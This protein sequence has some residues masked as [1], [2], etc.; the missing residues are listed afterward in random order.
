M[1]PNCGGNSAANVS[2]PADA[3][4]DVVHADPDE[5]PPRYLK[6]LRG[7][8]QDSHSGCQRVPARGSLAG[9][10]GGSEASGHAAVGGRRRLGEDRH[11][12]GYGRG[13]RLRL[14]WRRTYLATFR[15]GLVCQDQR[16][17]LG[18]WSR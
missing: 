14:T 11:P 4:L 9:R 12:L 5:Q 16:G 1:R 13:P 8:K 6:R 17:T 15:P 2:S 10:R 18:A 7:F 3:R